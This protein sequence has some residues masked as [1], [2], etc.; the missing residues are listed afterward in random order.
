MTDYLEGTIDKFFFSKHDLF[1][2][3]HI[4][5]QMAATPQG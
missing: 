4:A 3:F 1:L 5:Q 2:L